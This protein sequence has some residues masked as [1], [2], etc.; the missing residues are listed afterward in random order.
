MLGYHGQLR[1]YLKYV[2]FPPN[3]IVTSVQLDTEHQPKQ[4]CAP[5]LFK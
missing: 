2:Y 1:H 5:L 4:N 3:I